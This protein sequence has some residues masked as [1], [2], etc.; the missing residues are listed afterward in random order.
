VR[1]RR[2]AEIYPFEHAVFIF[3]SARRRILV[4]CSS[5]ELARLA[6]TATGTTALSPAGGRTG[7]L[8]DVWGD[9]QAYLDGCYVAYVPR[10]ECGWTGPPFSTTPS[11]Y[12]A[13]E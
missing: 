5:T 10:C 13:C 3:R 8:A 7:A 6:K 12:A 4:R 9:A 11:G 1:D 2:T